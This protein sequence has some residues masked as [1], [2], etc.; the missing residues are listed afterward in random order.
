MVEEGSVY[1]FIKIILHL[2]DEMGGACCCCGL[3]QSPG[4]VSKS[5]MNRKTR[6]MLGFF[7]ESLVMEKVLS[8]RCRNH[9]LVQ[10]WGCPVP[11]RCHKVSLRPQLTEITPPSYLIAAEQECTIASHQTASAPLVMGALWEEEVW[12]QNILRIRSSFE[13]LRDDRG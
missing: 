10:C 11:I 5:L 13:I 6:A 12:S 9:L 4:A 3:C 7:P 8:L 2:E 1:L